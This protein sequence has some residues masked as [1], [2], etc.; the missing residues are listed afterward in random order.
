MIMQV[1]DELVFDVY[2]PELETMQ[3][4]VRHHMT[5]AMSL[6]VPLSIDMKSGKDWLV[7]H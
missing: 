2:K 6:I 1:H 3:N 5:H 7:A 4:I